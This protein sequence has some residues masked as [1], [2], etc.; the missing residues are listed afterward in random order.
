MPTIMKHD[1]FKS[2]IIYVSSWEKDLV[3]VSV[4]Y[5]YSQVWCITR[6]HD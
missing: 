4:K 5:S 1:Y 3:V 6:W 2:N